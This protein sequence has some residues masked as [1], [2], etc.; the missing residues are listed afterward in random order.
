MIDRNGKALKPGDKVRRINSGSG[1]SHYEVA[2]WLDTDLLLKS[3]YS[4]ENMLVSR[5]YYEKV[6]TPILDR[7]G[8]PIEIGD[9]VWSI[10]FQEARVVV[11]PD[12]NRKRI[13]DTPAVFVDGAYGV[14]NLWY[15]KNVV[16]VK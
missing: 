13:S 2:E 5:C 15:A 3:K 14:K 8:T 4:D 7:L 10:E 9:R 1:D 11:D 12:L 6:E 16:V